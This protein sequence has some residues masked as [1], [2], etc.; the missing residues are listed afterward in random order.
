M[1]NTK[2]VQE[3]DKTKVEINFKK[4]NFFEKYRK[5]EI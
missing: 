5:I 4:P 3:I 1:D 2:L